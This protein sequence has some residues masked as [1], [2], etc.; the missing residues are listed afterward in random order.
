MLAW[1]FFYGTI[2]IRILLLEIQLIRPD[3]TEVPKRDKSLSA[4]IFF[5]S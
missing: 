4:I 3:L 5:Y 2:S 1:N